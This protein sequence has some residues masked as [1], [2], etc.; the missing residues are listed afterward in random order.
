MES[1]EEDWWSDR[2]SDAAADAE[3]RGLVSESGALEVV[4]SFDLL[5]R[6]GRVVAGR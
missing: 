5:R 6:P 1:L 2:L 3:D 4:S